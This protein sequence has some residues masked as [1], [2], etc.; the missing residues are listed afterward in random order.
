MR[1][2]SPL[3]VNNS[4]FTS[5]FKIYD[6][7]AQYGSNTKVNGLWVSLVFAIL[8]SYMTNWPSYTC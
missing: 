8:E 5:F 2:K 7:Q 1:T 3:S 6:G 4:L